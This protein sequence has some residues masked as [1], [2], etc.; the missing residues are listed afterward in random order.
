MKK[1][2]WM[3][4][5]NKLAGM[6]NDIVEIYNLLDKYYQEEKKKWQAKNSK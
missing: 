2:D 5:S 3:K 4:I 1:K 6:S